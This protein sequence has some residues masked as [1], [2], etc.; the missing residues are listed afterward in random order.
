MTSHGSD[1]RTKRTLEELNKDKEM[2]KGSDETN[3]L[4][5]VA[6]QNCHCFEQRNGT[7]NA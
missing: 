1:R 6:G 7:E 5:Q 4:F 2:G 3:K